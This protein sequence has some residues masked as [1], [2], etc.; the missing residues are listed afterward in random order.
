MKHYLNRL[1]M[2]LLLV[3][4]AVQAGPL[5]ASAESGQTGNTLFILDASGSMWGQ[6]GGKPKI[7]IAKEVMVK[8]LAEIPAGNRIGLIAYGHRR[9]ADCS[10]V[11]TLVRPGRNNK[12]KVLDAVKGLNARGKT[13]LTRSVNQAMTLLKG[14]K[15]TFAIVLVSDGIES[16]DADPCAAVKAAK[17]S[18]INF[19]LHTVGFGLSKKESTQLRCMAEAGGGQYFQANNA[20]QLLKSA[21]KAVQSAGILKLTVKVNGAVT[22]LTYRV[23]DAKT[24]K[25]IHEPVLGVPS[26]AALPLAGGRYNVFVSP[27]GVSGA[28]EKKLAISIK[29]GE[30]VEKTLLFDKGSLHLTVTVDGKPAHAAVH[31]EDPQNHQWIYQSSVFGVDTPLDIDLPVGKVDVVVQAGGR[32]VPEQRVEGVEIVADKATRQ[33]I[34]IEIKTAAPIRA[35]ANG[36]EQDTDRPGGGDFRHFSPASADPALCQ[37]ACQASAQC[38]AWTYVKPNSV[39]GVEPNCW[40]KTDMP[41]AVHN[42][43]CVSGL[44]QAEK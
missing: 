23:E 8:L 24:G 44:K 31:V 11:E 32:D 25:V 15:G 28:R 7:T 14:E 35:G 5:L 37:Q 33:V 26:G 38:R 3:T 42:T 9:K 10:D 2:A 4:S 22:D 16:C 17:A 29:S 36:M 13:P 41:A 6:I 30:V 21:R 43:C 20:E 40:L 34:P 19:V 18:G 27:A 1:V 39:Q 12:Q